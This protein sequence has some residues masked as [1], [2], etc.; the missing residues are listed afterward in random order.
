MDYYC[1]RITVDTTLVEP[2]IAFLSDYPFDTF[3]ESEIG[4]S[5][6]IPV[7]KWTEE[8]EQGVDDLAQR[9][10][11]QYV[12]QHIPHQNW[13]AVWESNFSP[14]V[15]DNFCIIRAEFHDPQP[16]ITH[17]ILIRPKM[18]FGTGHHATT[19][20]MM[21]AMENIN[22]S[23]ARVL[24]Y[25]CGTGILAILAEKLGATDIEAVD[26]E[27]EA[28]ENTEENAVL[29][30]CTSIH[31]FHGTLDVIQSSNFGI[32]LANINRNVILD[33]IAPLY[34]K[35][36][37]NGYLLASGL[38]IRDKELVIN[39]FVEQAYTFEK[40]WERGDWCCLLFS[41]SK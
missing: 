9:F 8:I 17:D 38:L 3:E 21:K 40:G 13:N 41:V 28:F 36:S 2:V 15:I 18:A 25:G 5:A 29:N 4:L 11:F 16:Q 35:L 1:F 20:M 33:S 39:A 23:N 24:D 37:A 31:P 27:K 12:R 7:D 19:Y 6:Y 34:A 22:F 30:D 14:I 32:V 26:I 10:A